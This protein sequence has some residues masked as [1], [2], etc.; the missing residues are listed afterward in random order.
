MSVKVLTLFGEEIVPEQ[1]NAVGRAKSVDGPKEPRKRKKKKNEE[2]TEEETI[3]A[4]HTKD[5]EDTLPIP[6]ET[7]NIT[8]EPTTEELPEITE[9]EIDIS[10]E[11][12]QAVNNM[13][14][15]AAEAINDAL[16]I[17]QEEPEKQAPAVPFDRSH[18]LRMARQR[19][20]TEPVNTVP[21]VAEKQEEPTT[22]LPVVNEQP[23]EAVATET[24]IP[25][26]PIDVTVSDTEAIEKAE[27]ILELEINP[28]L[29]EKETD[30]AVPVTDEA[31]TEE[32]KKVKKET[33]TAT[34]PKP[35]GRKKK[36]TETETTTATIVVSTDD[37][38]AGWTA[39]KQYYT[40]GEVATLFQVRTSNIRFWT[41]EFALK[42]RTTRKG[43]RLYT[44][45]QIREIR[46][47]YYLVKEKKYT[48]KGAKAKLKEQKK[49]TV[50]SLD[51][52]QSLLHLRNKLLTLRN[53]LV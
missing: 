31:V 28:D 26:Q 11:Q 23:A 42:V 5:T 12:P 3:D 38:L 44:P 1:L 16:E 52:K 25:Q 32:K 47:I 22:E 29:G 45:E 2:D 6:E 49:A 53:Q 50:Q 17:K 43:D 9:T 40:I 8:D 14:Q 27:D 37:I 21:P 34:V 10:A 13:A 33:K 46:T 24:D 18:F 48:I 4:T 19:L 36:I 39:D 35:R 7:G 15:E 41:N 20:V 51:L 30:T